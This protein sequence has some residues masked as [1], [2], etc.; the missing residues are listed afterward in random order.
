MADARWETWRGAFKIA[1]RL[2]QDSQPLETPAIVCSECGQFLAYLA[3]DDRVA[4]LMTLA[5]EHNCPT[6]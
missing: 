3:D 5:A 1:I 2:V 4:S 6:G